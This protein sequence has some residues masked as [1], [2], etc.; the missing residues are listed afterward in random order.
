MTIT[1]NSLLT[2][3]TE[4]L[5]TVLASE[6]GADQ[7]LSRYF[8][9]HPRFGSRDRRTLGDAVYG[10]LRR[11]R[12]LGHVLDQP[13][14]SDWHLTK[15]EARARLVAWM[16]NKDDGRREKTPTLLDAEVNPLVASL[17]ADQPPAVAANLPDWLY[18]ALASELGITEVRILAEALAQPASLDL[19]VNILRTTRA[20]VIRQ[21]QE[22]GIEAT[23]TPLS[24]VGLRLPTRIP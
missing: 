6:Q 20:E 1:S 15:V 22:E 2:V 8:Q 10:C 7:T 17:I 14:R 21:W 19:R 16:S 24:P 18:D 5:C 12:S 11:L 23:P 3:S 9:N 13:E 4:L